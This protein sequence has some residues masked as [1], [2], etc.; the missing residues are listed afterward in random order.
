MKL[1]IYQKYILT[2]FIIITLK[3]TL[4]F[5]TLVFILN[6]F[7]ELS[8]FKDLETNILTPTSLAL[9]NGPNVLFEI[10]PFVFLISTQFFYIKIIDNHELLAYK[11]FGLNNLKIISFITL[12][13]FL[14]GL[15][16]VV[17]FYNFSAKLKFLYL[18]NKNK[19]SLDNKYLAVITDN[20]IWIRDYINGN[21]NIINSKYIFRNNL[22]EVSITQFSNDFNLLLNIEADS[23]DISK[24]NWVLKNVTIFENNSPKIKKNELIF[25]THFDYKKI[26]NLFSNLYSLT[27]WRL[28][29]LR[30]E[31]RALKYSTMDLNVHL[32]MLISYPF[33]VCVMTILSSILM[34]NIKFNKSKIFNI[35]L[36]T[37]LSVIIYYIKYFFNVFGANQQLPVFFSN[38]LPIILLLIIASI[39]LVRINE[40]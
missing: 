31:Y 40:K 21:S 24:E 1:K 8:F 34:L 3:I 38:W 30:N 23:A 27:I 20:G 10:F 39:G 13:S 5:F 16:I 9:L 18:E 19:Y 2:D 14:M 17:F 11:K 25:E 7:E 6:L 4:I 12:L 15:F 33:F 32:N 36:G 35:I 26:S 37:M 28:F 22:E 29:E